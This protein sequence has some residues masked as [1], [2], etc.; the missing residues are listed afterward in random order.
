MVMMNDDLWSKI[1]D[2]VYGLDDVL[3]H[4]IDN[5][6]QN[7]SN[8]D[9][10]YVMESL[11]DEKDELED[12]IVKIGMQKIQ[13]RHMVGVLRSCIKSISNVWLALNNCKED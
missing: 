13:D 10:Q 7:V 5:E 6:I 3:T 12:Q 1:M 11:V 9:A 8:A 4:R 2:N